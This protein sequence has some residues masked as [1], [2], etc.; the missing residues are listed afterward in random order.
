MYGSMIQ[1]YNHCITDP[2][3]FYKKILSSNN[4]MNDDNLNVKNNLETAEFINNLPI[5]KLVKE[6]MDT[7]KMIQTLLS[8]I[9]DRHA[10]LV[11]ELVKI[12]KILEKNEKNSDDSSNSVISN[13]ELKTRKETLEEEITGKHNVILLHHLNNS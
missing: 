2:K 1:K 6:F 3:E 10:L 8:D 9:H 12:V 4:A 13:N 7:R 5:P 11:E